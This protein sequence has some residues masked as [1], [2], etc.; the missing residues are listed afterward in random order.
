MDSVIY[1]HIQNEKSAKD[2]WKK[3]Q[4]TFEDNGL[5]RRV[6]LLRTLITTQLDQCNN[7]EDYVNRIITNAQKLRGAGMDL[8]DEWIGTLLLL[9]GLSARYEPIHKSTC[10]RCSSAAKRS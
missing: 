7:M 10:K 4:D 8:N 9:A 3:L 2:V 1:G 6:G 5:T